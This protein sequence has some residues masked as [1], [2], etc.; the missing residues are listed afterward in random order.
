MSK[1]YERFFLLLV[2]IFVV[3]PIQ[4]TKDKKKPIWYQ[5]TRYQ[6]KEFI[7]FISRSLDKKNKKQVINIRISNNSVFKKN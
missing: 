1:W 3:C 4:S 7:K 6:N 5:D 2:F